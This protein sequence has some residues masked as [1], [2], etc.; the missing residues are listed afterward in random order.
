MESEKE[1][2]EKLREEE[3]DKIRIS[4]QN[5]L[6]RENWV[7]QRVIHTKSVS[8]VCFVSGGFD[9]NDGFEITEGFLSLL[10]VIKRYKHET[11]KVDLFH[12]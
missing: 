9:E 3:W 7:N 8:E 6:S 2:I 10:G 12:L 1:L 4:R 5:A 11:D